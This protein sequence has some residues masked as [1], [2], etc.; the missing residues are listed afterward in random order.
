MTTDTPRTPDEA[1]AKFAADHP[2]DA[3]KEAAVAAKAGNPPKDIFEAEKELDAY[4]AKHPYAWEAEVLQEAVDAI[5][6]GKPFDVS[7]AKQALHVAAGHTPEASKSL[8]DREADER[9]EEG[10]PAGGFL[11][12]G[13]PDR[14][15]PAVNKVAP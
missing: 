15:G 9:V 2:F 11:Y 1:A 8:L 14:N 13:H 7:A 3:L 10:L 5:A 6:A 12:E 4:A